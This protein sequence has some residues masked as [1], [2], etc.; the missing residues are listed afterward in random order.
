MMHGVVL[1]KW[2]GSP[3]LNDKIRAIN[4]RGRLFCKIEKVTKLKAERGT[5][6]WLQTL[7][8]TAARQLLLEWS[9]KKG[10]VKWDGRR[11]C[12]VIIH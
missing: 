10:L 11:L 8:S 12:V 3:R 9:V 5:S 6:R 4:V 7:N 1:D 2:V